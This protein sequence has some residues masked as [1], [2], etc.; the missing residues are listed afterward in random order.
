MSDSLRY[1][2]AFTKEDEFQAR[3]SAKAQSREEKKGIREKISM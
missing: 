3:K 1:A 2:R